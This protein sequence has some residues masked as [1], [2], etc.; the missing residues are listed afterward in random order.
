MYNIQQP[1]CRQQSVFGHQVS[2]GRKVLLWM[3]FF[4][5]FDS[6]KD[7]FS[8]PRRYRKQIKMNLVN[9]K[10]DWMSLPHVRN[11][12]YLGEDNNWCFNHWISSQINPNSC[13]FSQVVV[14]TVFAVFLAKTVYFFLKWQWQLFYYLNTSTKYFLIT[15]EN[16]CQSLKTSQ[17]TTLCFRQTRAKKA[18]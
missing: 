15:F 1:S 8:K 18:H 3:D 4:R 17:K 9:L 13:N 6:E 5:S 2:H 16:F 12:A 10:I 7:I 11:G 14:T